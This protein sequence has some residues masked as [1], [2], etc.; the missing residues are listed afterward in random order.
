MRIL[1]TGA[2]G[3]IGFHLVKRLAEKGNFIYGIDSIND[4]YDVGLKKSRLEACGITGVVPHKEYRSTVYPTYRFQQADICEQEILE[5]IFQ[6]NTFDCVVNLAAQAGVRYSLTHPESYI[7]SNLV[8]YL[9]LLELCKKFSCPRFIYA[10]SSSVY[11]NDAQVPFREDA[12][13]DHPVSIYA[14]TKKS[15]ELM[16]YTYS[17][18]YRLQTVGLRFFTVYG[19]YGRP[20]M[21]PML[22]AKAIQNDHAVQ[23]F[24]NGQLAR[25]F[26]YIDD[27]IEGIVKIIDTPQLVREDQPGTPAVVYNIGHGSPTQLMDFIRL[28]EENFG[29]T[30]RKEFVG[31]QPG[32]VYQTWADTHKLEEDYHYVPSTPLEKGI[33]AFAD[34]YKS[35]FSFAYGRSE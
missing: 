2:A 13:A 22:F 5:K 33:R 4:Y 11:G 23:V 35:Y 14:A 1:V 8:G 12:P 6:E 21:A 20:D 28:L 27:I 7:Q 32:D 31:M 9:N 15:N 34:W 29:K 16:A 18:L 30:V 3:F 10:S 26:T 24:N 19:P 17:H 25:D